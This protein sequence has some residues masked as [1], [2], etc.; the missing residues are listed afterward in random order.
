MPLVLAIKDV[1][2]WQSFLNLQGRNFYD[3]IDH[4]NK[5]LQSTRAD[6]LVWGYEED[7]KIRLNFQV[8]NQYLK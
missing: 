3:F 2:I 6:I 5:I 1:L 7:G 8:K 4:G